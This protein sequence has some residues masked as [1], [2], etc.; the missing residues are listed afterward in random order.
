MPSIHERSLTVARQARPGRRRPCGVRRGPPQG[1][2]SR[3]RARGELQPRERSPHKITRAP[4]PAGARRRPA[5]GPPARRGVRPHGDGRDSHRTDGDRGRGDADGR[6]GVP[7]LRAVL[8]GCRCRHRDPDHHP[9]HAGW[10][11]HRG[12]PER[13]WDTGN[14]RRQRHGGHAG[15]HPHGGQAPE[16]GGYPRHGHPN[17]RRARDPRGTRRDGDHRADGAVQQHGR[18]QLGG[19]RRYQLGNPW[20]PQHVGRH[21]RVR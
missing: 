10:R 16:R 14:R 5:H 19:G 11:R 13:G 6:A 17:L 8:H 7:A 12:L 18:R 21:L 20:G 15:G 9:G 2:A 3:C 1:A 4:R